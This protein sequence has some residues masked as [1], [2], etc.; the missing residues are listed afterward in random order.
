[1][2][3]FQYLSRTTNSGGID[4]TTYYPGV[5]INTGSVQPINMS[6]YEQYGLDFEKQYINWFVPNLNANDVD[7]DKSGDVIE[8]L[9]KRWQLCGG[10]DWGGIDGWKVMTAV[11]IGPAT[12]NITNA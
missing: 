12:G 11:Y 9:G 8:T 10:N 5:L 6:K 7:R 3:Y 4:V 1:M 2:T